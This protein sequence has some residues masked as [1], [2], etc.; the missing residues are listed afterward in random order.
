MRSAGSTSSSLL[1][2]AFHLILLVVSLTFFV[3]LVQCLPQRLVSDIPMGSGEPLEILIRP[4][5]DA[6]AVSRV[7]VA[8]GLTDRPGEL[9]R[10]FAKVGIDRRLRPGLYRI[11]RGSPWEIARQM[12]LAEPE[13]SGIT[14]YPGETFETLVAR[15]GETFE[16]ALGKDELFPMEIRPFLPGEPRSRIAFLLPETYN[17]TPGE[18]N[19]EELVMAA[20]ALWM[21]K[22]GKRIPDTGSEAA[23]LLEKAIVASLVEREAK[24]PQEGFLI[25]GVIRNRS[26]AG[27]KLQIDATIVYAWS[28]RG[29]ELKRVLYR[30]LEIDSPYNTYLHAGLPPAPICSPSEGSWL[31]SLEPGEEP[32]LFYVAMPDGSHLFSRT[33]SEHSEA[34]RRS[35]KAFGSSRR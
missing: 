29:V 12:A 30:D 15:L 34:I 10:W 17:V 18:G 20:S 1:G 6:G 14:L 16:G 28:L 24:H 5:M 33:F 8:A 11:R 32:F 21:K 31:A 9:T 27:M 7:F 23:F 35:R 25:A 19:V 3:A 26:A 22:V 13:V 2:K 4:G